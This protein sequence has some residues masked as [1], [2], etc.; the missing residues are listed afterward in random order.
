MAKPQFGAEYLD[1]K[2]LPPTYGGCCPGI[3]WWYV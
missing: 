1:E 3:P 2:E